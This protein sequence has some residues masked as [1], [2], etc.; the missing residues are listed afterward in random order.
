MTPC[1][2]CGKPL[3]ADG[4]ETVKDK[5]HSMSGTDT[6]YYHRTCRPDLIVEKGHISG[7]KTF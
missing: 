2:K 5:E 3:P 4:S 6:Y 1:D 7:R